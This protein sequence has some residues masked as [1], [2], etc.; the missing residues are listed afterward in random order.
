MQN[1]NEAKGEFRALGDPG[2]SDPTEF[3]DPEP[4]GRTLADVQRQ[5]VPHSRW[6]SVSF[7]AELDSGN[8]VKQQNKQYSKSTH[9]ERVH[10]LP[11]PAKGHIG[12]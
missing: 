11:L 8:G 1:S 4:L 3:A 10:D 7:H 2:N 9:P 5:T 6:S 12:C